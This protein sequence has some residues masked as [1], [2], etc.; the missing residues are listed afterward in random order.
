MLLD[1]SQRVDVKS[2]MEEGKRLGVEVQTERLAEL[3]E[4]VS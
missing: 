4:S 1:S 2:I 3:W